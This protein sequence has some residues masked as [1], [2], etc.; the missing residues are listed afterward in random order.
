MIL[1]TPKVSIRPSGTLDEIDAE[2]FDGA[3][4]KPEH[5]SAKDRTYE[6]VWR[7]IFLMSTVHMFAIYGG[8][9]MVTGQIMWQTVLFGN[10]LNQLNILLNLIFSKLVC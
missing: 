7:N 4:L 5:R 9:R 10:I 3:L 6:Y 2:T 8:W 1:K